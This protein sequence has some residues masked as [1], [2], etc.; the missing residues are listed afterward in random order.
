MAFLNNLFNSVRSR[1]DAPALQKQ[2]LP[3]VTPLKQLTGIGSML[4]MQTI[5]LPGG[6]TVQIP[7]LNMEEINANL[8]ASG[9]TPQIRLC[10]I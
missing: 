7:Q 1:R 10:S 5:T 9:I 4:P 3:Q 8:A 6:Q 2:V